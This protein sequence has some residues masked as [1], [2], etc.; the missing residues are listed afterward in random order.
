MKSI[1]TL[2]IE[3][4]QLDDPLAPITGAKRVWIDGRPGGWLMPEISQA[5]AEASPGIQTW[6][7]PRAKGGPDVRLA[8]GGASII[9]FSDYCKKRLIPTYPH[10]K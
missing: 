9:S 8:D 5:T 10:T 3:D 1:K 4:T 6:S 2:T 7:H